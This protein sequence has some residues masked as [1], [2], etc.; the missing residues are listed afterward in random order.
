VS[1]AGVAWVLLHSLYH[2]EYI[3]GKVRIRNIP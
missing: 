2:N 1:G 3:V